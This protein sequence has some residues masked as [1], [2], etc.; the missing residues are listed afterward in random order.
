M[1]ALR[2]DAGGIWE[3]ESDRAVTGFVVGNWGIMYSAV[4]V[5]GNEALLA[6]VGVLIQKRVRQL[7][8]HVTLCYCALWD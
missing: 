3:M 6:E 2:L 1:Y 5:Q 4:C 8:S 7:H